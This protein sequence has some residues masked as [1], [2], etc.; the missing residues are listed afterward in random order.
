MSL[1]RVD[2]RHGGAD[3]RLESLGDVVRRLERDVS[4][5]LHVQRQLVPPADLDEREVV[6]LAHIRNGDGRSVRA[7]PDAG[8]DERLDVNDDVASGQRALE[9]LLDRVGRGMPLADRRRRRARR[10]RR[11]RTAA[12]RLA[13][14]GAG[15]GRPPASSATIAARAAASASAGARSI[16][17]STLPRI[18]RAAASSTSTATKSAAIESP[19][20]CPARDEQRARRAPRP[21]PAR[22]L[23]KWSA[24]DAE[25]GARVAPRRPPG[26]GRAARVD[27]DHDEHHAEHVPRR[28]HGVRAA[29]RTAARSARTPIRRSPS[30]RNAAS[31]SAAR[32]S[33]LPWPYWCD[34]SAGRPATPIAKI[35]QQRGDE[36]GA[37]VDGFG[38]EAE[39]V[40]G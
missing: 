34:T 21:S 39:A 19:F 18:S 11:R 1:D 29:S 23:A 17:T 20:G 40:R 31:A 6:D 35:G 2:L 3:R 7:H 13:A 27:R 16:S 37:G 30:D 10:S 9:R 25:R 36:I 8:I 12:R 26:D 22:S 28:V 38:D 15:A 4:G 24:F 14:S 32:C 33:A 5:Q